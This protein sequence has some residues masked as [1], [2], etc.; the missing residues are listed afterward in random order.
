MKVSVALCTFNGERYLKDQL[1]SIL[2][3][4][5]MPD[6]LIVCD[7]CSTDNSMNIIDS[8][9]NVAPFRI[10]VCVNKRQIG[11]TKNFEQA[12]SKCEGDLIFLSDQDD[13]W[14]PE[15]IEI[16]AKTC[17]GNIMNGGAF[18]DAN[19]VDENLQP[20][21]KTLW[22][23]VG[24]S[25]K[26]QNKFSG[27]GAIEIL[28]KQ[29]VVTGATL[30]FSAK[31]KNYL[32]PIPEIW[33]HDAW[34][35]LLLA[36]RSNLQCIPTPLIKYR[37]HHCQQIGIKNYSFR[38]R[39]DEAK[40]NNRNTYLMEAERYRLAGSRIESPGW[41]SDTSD[42][43]AII[44]EKINHLQKR[45]SIDNYKINRLTIPLSELFKGR[46]HHYSF[47]WKSFMK[48]IIIGH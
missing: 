24:F 27:R 9:R 38:Q 14:N 5:V 4:T 36:C 41:L 43:S 22:N 46:Y 17:R 20:L 16:T 12:I 37:Q 34:I 19:I 35:A 7:D 6:E 21:N 40:R 47:G 42:I 2:Q 28:L 11:S 23:T 33:V 26:Q 31:Y 1:D 3:Q 18:S 15:K 30:A 32:L 8:L 48:D 39:I 10:R 44:E 25:P 13:W 45:S 29:N